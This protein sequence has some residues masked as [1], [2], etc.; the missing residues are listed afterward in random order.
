MD[1]NKWI[2]NFVPHSL[3]LNIVEGDERDAKAIESELLPKPSYY[4]TIRKN[5]GNNF[6]SEFDI[7]R[8]ILR[9]WNRKEIGE[10][11]KY[12]EPWRNHV[13]RFMK[14]LLPRTRIT[15]A[16]MDELYAIEMA[17]ACRLEIVNLI[18]HKSA[19]KT[20]LMARIALT[21][22]CVDPD[23]S[24]AYAAAPYKNVAGYTIWS[25]VE[26]CYQEIEK[27]HKGVFPDLLSKKADSTFQI[28]GRNSKAG[29]I[30]LIGLDQVSKFQGTKQYDDSRGF[31][32]LIADETGVFP[33]HAFI[34]IIGNVT[35]NKGF[36]GITGCNFKNTLGM[37]G[38]LCEPI[39]GEYNNLDVERDH[40]W[41]SAYKSVTIRLD[42][43][44]CPNVLAKKEIYGFLLSEEKRQNLEDIHGPRGPK[45]LEQARSF[46]NNSSGD[47]FVL[48]MDQMR[49]GGAFD[50]FWNPSGSGRW[51]RTSFCD[52]GWGGDPCKWMALEFGAAMV[53]AHDG[54]MKPIMIMRPVGAI[55]T[56]RVQEG[57]TV[58]EETLKDLSRYSRGPIMVKEGRDLSMDMQIALACAKLN[59]EHGI[60]PANF[61]FDSSMRGG[62]VQE[63][64]TI[65]GPEIVAYDGNSKASQMSCGAQGG[66]AADKYRNLRSE[67]FF[68]VASIVT[69]GQFRDADLVRDAF[70]QIC[71]HKVVLAGMKEGIESKD[72]FKEANQ[73]KSPDAG[74]CLC[75]AAHMA[76]RR[77][78]EM[79][80]NKREAAQTYWTPETSYQGIRP[81]PATARLRS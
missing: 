28:S 50:R 44:L 6:A 54:S 18:G 62:I 52:P 61:G 21:L 25:E 56:I 51:N 76:R 34:E 30:R 64:V 7:E 63:M 43:H 8:S 41:L 73:G 38:V 39:K 65:L 33:S 58:T 3:Q 57:L 47:R 2:E 71:R 59:E 29:F 32:I 78:F 67:M 53:Q 66:I 15:P 13:A 80:H 48:T 4:E 75:G 26:S 22:I 77:G 69:S 23:Y 9:K 72:K 46:P 60:P 36:L 11:G 79:A 17:L 42:G 31:F 49:S 16:F 12:G 20:A 68:N 27:H 35:V 19:G 10:V 37:E 45:Y 14:L 24:V 1:G 40:I 55:Q 70:G 5:L 74:D 81:R